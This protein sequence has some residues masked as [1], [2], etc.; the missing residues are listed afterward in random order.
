MT[1]GLLKLTI[2]EAKLTRDT[3]D[4]GQMDPFVCIAYREFRCRTKTMDG[5][6][7]T[8]VWNEEIEIDVKYIGDDIKL[9]VKDENVTDDDLI[10]ETEIKVSALCFPGG[11]DDWWHIAWRGKKVGELRMK[12]DWTPTGTDPVAQAAAEKP[13]LSASL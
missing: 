3:E 5:A 9:T 1:S 13:G 7:M 4:F 10:G 12:G 6:G 8:P 11:I 2:V